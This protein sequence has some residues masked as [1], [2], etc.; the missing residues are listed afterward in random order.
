MNS[1]SASFKK[2]ILEDVNHDPEE[3][4]LIFRL[5]DTDSAIAILVI[6]LMLRINPPQDAGLNLARRRL[7]VG[8]LLSF[9]YF[10]GVMSLGMDYSDEW[11]FMEDTN[12]TKYLLLGN[13]Y[14][15]VLFFV[16]S[17]F[18]AVWITL[19]CE[20]SRCSRTIR[21]PNDQIQ[22]FL[23]A[24]EQNSDQIRS[25]IATFFRYA[26]SY[27]GLYLEK[28]LRNEVGSIR[29]KKDLEIHFN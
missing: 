7:T 24:G 8:K 21:I 15:A 6:E 2:L 27:F 19:S 5:M 14:P 13:D 1:L 4:E 29:A 28:I 22:M 3:V 10:S 18:N 20:T 17:V 11:L 23:E 16:H 26:A 25:K 9:G 12:N